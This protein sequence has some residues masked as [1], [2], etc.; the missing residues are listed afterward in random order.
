MDKKN[1]LLFASSNA[2][3]VEEVRQ[4]L[5]SKYQLLGLRDIHWTSDI[6]EPFDTF[7]DNAK[8]KVSFVFNESGYPCIADDSGLEIDTLNGRPGV[9]SARYAGEQ[10]NSNDNIIKVL[11][12]LGTDAIRTARFTAVIACQL[13]P[14]EVYIFK[15]QVE[16][17]IAY[18]P[19]GTCG[20]GYDSVFIPSGFDRT[21][22]ELSP[23]VKNLISH[24]ALAMRKFLEFLSKT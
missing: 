1:T 3:K 18:Q 14:D 7:E 20:F 12:E 2:H 19:M 17:S 24:R 13:K 6:P 23:L 4:L 8:A 21:F 11:T 16:G 9:Y 15:G 10:R 22:G 5:P